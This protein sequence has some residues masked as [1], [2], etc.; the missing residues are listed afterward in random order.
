[1]K[2]AQLRE[3]MLRRAAELARSGKYADFLMIEHALKMEG[4]KKARLWLDDRD[5][6]SE[7]NELCTQHRSKPRG[8]EE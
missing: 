7:L 5:T 1:M 4:Y 6:R 8:T 3:Q 2:Q